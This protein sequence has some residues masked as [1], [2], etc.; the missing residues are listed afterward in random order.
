MWHWCVLRPDIQQ[1]GLIFLKIWE[2]LAQNMIFSQKNPHWSQVQKRQITVPLRKDFHQPPSKK[3]RHS[4]PLFIE[5]TG[6]CPGYLGWEVREKI[7]NAQRLTLS[8]S[9]KARSAAC[10]RIY[11]LRTQGDA[12]FGP[13]GYC[14][15][16][17]SHCAAP[18][19]PKELLGNHPVL[20]QQ[21][22]PSTCHRSYKYEQLKKWGWHMPQSAFQGACFRSRRAPFLNSQ[23]IPQKGGR[24]TQQPSFNS[25]SRGTDF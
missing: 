9:K 12:L 22:C 15:R 5:D 4:F 11:A 7:G 23:P 6:T 14:T 2:K 19:A 16:P 20:P 3:P 1:T 18:Q 8:L 21:G 25:I 13:L 17:E 10:H 24:K